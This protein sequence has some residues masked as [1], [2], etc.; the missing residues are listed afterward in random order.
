MRD[1][2]KVDIVRVFGESDVHDVLGLTPDEFIVGEI[3]DAAMTAFCEH[4]C[5]A[6]A[7]R[8]AS[9]DGLI[10][11]ARLPFEIVNDSAKRALDRLAIF[12]SYWSIRLALSRSSRLSIRDISTR[13]Y[14]AICSSHGF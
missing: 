12:A 5:L 4:R 6:H 9:L 11:V 8:K 3:S 1:A 7:D 13:K 10:G 14:V 2:D